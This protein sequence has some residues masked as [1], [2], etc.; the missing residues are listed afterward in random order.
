MNWNW[1]IYV[2]L[3]DFK[4]SSA[5]YNFSYKIVSNYFDIKV[6][7]KSI[8]KKRFAASFSFFSSLAQ[9]QTGIPQ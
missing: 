2:Y 4:D 1:I 3:K 6:N 7:S 5:I 8:P 9:N